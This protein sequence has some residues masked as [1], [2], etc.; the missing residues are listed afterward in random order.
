VVFLVIM[1]IT[2]IQIGLS[3]YWVHYE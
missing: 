2:L 3:R 1:V